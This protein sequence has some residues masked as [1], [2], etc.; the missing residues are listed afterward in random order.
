[1]KANVLFFDR[2]PAAA[3]P[4]T[5]DVWVHDLRTNMHF[6][7]KTDP[8][9]R[10]DLDAFVTCYNPANRH[11]RKP[12][13]YAEGAPPPRPSPIEGE[14]VVGGEVG[15]KGRWRTYGY[16]ELVARDKASLDIFWLKDE[17]LDDGDKLPASEVIAQQIVEDLEAALEQFRL[18]AGDLNG[19][20]AH[21]GLE[22]DRC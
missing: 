17:S 1:V 6:T 18:I 12:T 21:A 8:L 2:K 16:D 10:E 11:D 7:L 13:W 9:K 4:W 20:A 22:Q 14:G 15:E 5:K 19:A 3:D